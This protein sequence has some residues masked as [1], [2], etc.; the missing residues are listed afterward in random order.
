VGLV[1]LR[2]LLHRGDELVYTSTLTGMFAARDTAGAAHG[3]P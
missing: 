2:A 3:E 1:R